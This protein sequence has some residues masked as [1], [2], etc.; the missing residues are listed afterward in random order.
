[1]S[2]QTRES[3]TQPTRPSSWL[4]VEVE[5]RTVGFW[6]AVA[7]AIAVVVLG[8]G[9]WWVWGLSQGMAMDDD[10]GETM[11][12]MPHTDVRLPPPSPASTTA[13]KSISSTPRP[14]TPRSHRR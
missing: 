1:M 8:L 14:P 6:I 7:L 10:R 2:Q 9:A 3:D 13:R 4:S 11:Q 5:G 12:H